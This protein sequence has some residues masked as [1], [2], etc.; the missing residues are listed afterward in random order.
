MRHRYRYCILHCNFH[1]TLKFFEHFSNHFL[2]KA[3]H[4]CIH[5]VLTHF[6]VLAVA[7]GVRGARKSAVL[8]HTL[9]KKNGSSNKVVWLTVFG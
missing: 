1:L 5:S 8:P 6:K 4:D 2:Y 7:K 3:H 9:R